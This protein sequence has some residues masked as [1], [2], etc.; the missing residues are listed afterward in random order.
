MSMIPIKA[1]SGNP[2]AM[3]VERAFLRIKMSL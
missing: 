3:F 1:R 2:K